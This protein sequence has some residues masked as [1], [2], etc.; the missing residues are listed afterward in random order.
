M[1]GPIKVAV[2]RNTSLY[3]PLVTRGLGVDWNTFESAVD[4]FH[5]NLGG[6]YILLPLIVVHAGAA[7]Y[8][9]YVVRDRTLLRMLF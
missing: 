8:H 1:Y 2:F 3:D 4:W 7:L 9:H 5:K 6:V